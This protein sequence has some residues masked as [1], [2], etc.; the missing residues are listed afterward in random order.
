MDPIHQHTIITYSK[1]YFISNEIVLVWNSWLISK[2]TVLNHGWRS[3]RWGPNA[4]NA[5]DWQDDIRWFL[6]FLRQHVDMSSSKHVGRQSSE[7]LA[8]SVLA[9]RVDDSEQS[10]WMHQQQNNVLLQ[11]T[12][13][14]QRLRL[15]LTI[16]G[17]AS[18]AT[19]WLRHVYRIGML[20]LVNLKF[21]KPV[22]ADGVNNWLYALLMC[23]YSYSFVCFAVWFERIQDEYVTADRFLTDFNHGRWNSLYA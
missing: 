14:Y 7:D 8:R 1:F 13:F 15:R 5:I 10:G 22:T 21:W 9:R 11:S 12:G 23:T 20:F 2:G 19:A 3:Y 6:Q 4:Y 18:F 16:L 17:Y